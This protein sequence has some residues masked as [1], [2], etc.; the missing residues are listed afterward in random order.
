M[1]RDTECGITRRAAVAG[2]GALLGTAAC[3]RRSSR[4]ISFWAIGREGEMAAKLVEQFVR[5]NPDLE[6][7]IQKLPWTAAHEKL[8]TAYAG[9]TLPDLC[10][11]GNTWVPEFAELDAL[12][13]LDAQ[14]A[15][16][17]SVLTADYFE[18]ILEANRVSGR[19]LGLPWYVD[20]RLLFYR[21]DLLQQAGFAAPPTTWA[22]W[23]QMLAAIKAMVGPERYGV[24]L[25]L[26]EFE[27]LLILGLQQP[28]ELLREGGRWGNFRNEGFRRALHYYQQMF[29]REWAPRM[30][31]TQISNV[32]DEFA[33]GYFT[34]YVSGPWQIAQFKR[35]MPAHLQN[36][37][38]TA[39][40]P[41]PEGPGVSVAGGA[42]LVIF[43]SS[44]RKAQAW[45]LA[46]FLSSVSTQTRFYELTGDLPPR[47]E[48]WG[49]PA[50]AESRYARAF[51]QQLD[52]VRAPP[53][54]PEWARIATEL[55][56]MAERVVQ[57][58][59]DVDTGVR[60]LDAKVDAILEKR[61]WLLDRQ[62]SA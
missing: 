36:S 25:P 26:N 18:G 10:Q 55:C 48:V 30:T 5:L 9:D 54:V 29:T 19:L 24:L 61:R 11:M 53:K 17:G 23:S 58:Q 15:A 39:P 4:A 22:E 33:R 45:R 21:T 51:R 7:E 35:R 57:G 13:P 38:M 59:S 28:E 50:L 49:L 46:E 6:V 44:Q 62:E 3:S 42:S 31:N 2:L 37:W 16:S 27:Q 20:T 34:F 40:M 12:E 56:L 1:S 14:I 60:Q 8:L 43:R 32:W 52:R 47:R 41:G